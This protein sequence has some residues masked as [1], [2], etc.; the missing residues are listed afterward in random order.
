MKNS[1]RMKII[2]FILI[3]IAGLSSSA[4]KKAAVIFVTDNLEQSNGTSLKWITS[5]VY[6]E[7]GFNLY[8]NIKGTEGWVR[9]NSNPIKMNKELQE[10]AFDNVNDFKMFEASRKVTY[11]VFQENDFLK[12]FVILRAIQSNSLSSA[13]GMLSNDEDVQRGTLVRYQLKNVVEGK[14]VLL[15]ETDFYDV[16]SFRKVFPPD[17]IQTMR[18]KEEIKFKWKPEEM[19]YFGVEIYRSSNGDSSTLITE[20]P[21]RVQKND[22]GEFSEFQFTDSET[23]K[24][25][26]YEYQLAAVDYFG[27]RSKLSA[28][29]KIAADNVSDFSA[30]MIIDLSTKAFDLEVHLKWDI[31]VDSNLLGYNI[32]VKR[33][34]DSDSNKINA[35]LLNKSDTSYFFKETIPGAKYVAVEAVY[36]DGNKQSR[37]VYVEL[38][39]IIPPK[40]PTGLEVKSDTGIVNFIWSGNNEADLAG[41]KLYRSIADENNQDNFWVAVNANPIDSSKFSLSISK[42]VR[43]RF[44]YYVIAE[45]TNFNQSKPSGIVSAQMPDVTP[46]EKPLIISVE[47]LEV[48]QNKLLMVT[49]LANYDLDLKG[50]NLYR[51]VKEDT[52]EFEKVNYN[53]LPTEVNRYTDRS[54]KSGIRYEYRVDAIDT[55]NL[56]SEKSNSFFGELPMLAKDLLPTN[57]SINTNSKKKTVELSWDENVDKTLAGYTIYEGTSKDNMTPKSGL[58]QVNKYKLQLS[59]GTH[60]LQLRVVSTAGMI[61]KTEIIET[62]IITK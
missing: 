12:V 6:S 26:A 57:I 25:K 42:N 15:G 10:S 62:K 19:R 45:D 5:E 1:S 55:N 21:I 2:Y 43:N 7:Q 32:W 34:E 37:Y 38:G 27:R 14:E 52:V 54:A 46:P 18:A 30:P 11:S 44:A 39:D 49:W 13:I 29:I 3:L 41:Y 56:T 48:G 4:Q 28:P 22:N 50:Y 35:Q 58:F 40:T 59:E 8:R 24:S 36:K 20:Q 17:S 47:A 33:G 53:I 31:Q 9:V 23:D 60:F 16:G 61:A 51:R